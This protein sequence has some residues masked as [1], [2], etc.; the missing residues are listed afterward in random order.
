MENILVIL[1]QPVM[2]YGEYIG[3]QPPRN[4]T[5]LCLDDPSAPPCPL[6]YPSI[7]EV[8]YLIGDWKLSWT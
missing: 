8:R 6:G 2:Y 3:T 1:T 5:H 4:W 7:G